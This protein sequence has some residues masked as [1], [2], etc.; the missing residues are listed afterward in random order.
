MFDT[1]T[2][3]HT[4]A[5]ADLLATL[6]RVFG[7]RALNP[8]QSR[9]IAAVM[10]GHDVL[11]VAPTGSGKS[12]C[13][14]LPAALDATGG[15]TLVVAPLIAL[16]ED[17]VAG[18]RARGVAAA[19]LHGL[20][21]PAA[22][23]AVLHAVACGQVRLLYVAPERLVQSAGLAAA[24][25]RCGVRRMVVDEAHCLLRWGPDFRPDY[26][27][28][29]GVLTHLGE[30]QVIALTA[31]ASREEQRE[32]LTRL[33]R[34]RGRRVVAGYD[35][36]ELYY[37]VCLAATSAAKVRVLATALGRVDGP[38]IVY[39]GTRGE[40]DTVA[41]WLAQSRGIAAAAYHA[42][43]P[44]NARD[45]V[46]HA[47]MA[48]RLRVVVGTSAFGM[49]VDKPDVRAVV[50]W[51]LPADLT[52][53][54]QATGRA[55]RDGRLALAL[56]IF[57]PDDRRLREWQI[58]GD[59]PSVDAFGAVFIAVAARS[60]RGGAADERGIAAAAGLSLPKVRPALNLL[61]AEGIVRR[62]GGGPGSWAVVRPPHAGELAELARRAAERTRQR[63]RALEAVV[64]YA[65]DGRCRRW[66]ILAHLGAPRPDPRA[67]CC[68]VC[69]ATI[70]GGAAVRPASA[71][72]S[73]RPVPVD[74]D[75]RVLEVI[76]AR[77][78]RATVRG[79]TMVLVG[80]SSTSAPGTVPRLKDVGAAVD[81]LVEA[82]QVI[83]FHGVEPPRLALTRRGRD[84]AAGATTSAAPVGCQPDRASD[85]GGGP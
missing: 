6:T 60:G 62:A 50:H 69:R 83:V 29:A 55:G 61:L 9:A 43:L 16:I 33:G 76:R 38:A 47:F 80:A 39:V 41:R 67:A 64:R 54:A 66:Q 37:S 11:V 28:L 57:H 30:P 72:D 35:R 7:H 22:A 71:G 48:D 4:V 82:K 44:P 49:G 14:Q 3:D 81:R 75:S 77:D 56:L 79:L 31:T 23:A 27:R 15:L 51:T 20:Q 32:I 74:L 59:A 26:G 58:A 78:G 10:A 12:L 53:Y 19:G 17:Q 52:E 46:Q 8:V 73:R 45:A 40:A 36:P 18:L 65:A 1:S 2:I 70:D 13:F 21:S 84:A 34:P 42:G 68:D 85:N 63:C 24:L 5:P 25:A